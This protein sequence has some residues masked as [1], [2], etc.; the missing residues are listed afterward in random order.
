MSRLSIRCRASGIPT[1]QVHLPFCSSAFSRW[2]GELLC[3]KNY[4]LKKMHVSGF[5]MV[6]TQNKFKI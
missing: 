2:H 1:P 6:E 3:V 4:E 5:L